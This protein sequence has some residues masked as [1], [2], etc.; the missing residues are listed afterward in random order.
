MAGTV[1]GVVQVQ[2]HRSQL[3][4][5]LPRLLGAVRLSKGRREFPAAKVWGGEA[6]A[7]PHPPAKLV[8]V[9]GR[10]FPDAGPEFNLS[11]DDVGH[12]TQ[13]KRVALGAVGG[14]VI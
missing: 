14:G 5:A 13:R 6:A 12:V 9:L 8:A 11:A 3:I 4:G 7:V 1:G 2:Q 10:V